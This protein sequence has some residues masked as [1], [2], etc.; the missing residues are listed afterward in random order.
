MEEGRKGCLQG[1]VVK[2]DPF[3]NGPKNSPF[4]ENSPFHVSENGLFSRN[5]LFFGQYLNGSF[6][7]TGPWFIK[8]EKMLLRGQEMNKIT[9]Y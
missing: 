9:V 3:R 7:T 6:F 5:G 8:I 1:P 2:N 4:R